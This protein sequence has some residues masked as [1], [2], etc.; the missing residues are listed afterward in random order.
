MR[1]ADKGIVQR[2]PLLQMYEVELNRIYE[3][4]R[5]KAEVDGDRAPYKMLVEVE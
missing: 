2:G 4:V 1:R 3:E 5:D